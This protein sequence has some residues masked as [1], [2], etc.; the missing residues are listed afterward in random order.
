MK[1]VLYL[2]IVVCLFGICLCAISC[3]EPSGSPEGSGTDSET[4]AG[5][6][7]DPETG[8]T[9]PTEKAGDPMK[10]AFFITLA[11]AVVIWIAALILW[12]DKK[13]KGEAK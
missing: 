13:K 9:A 4:E 12:A 5:A 8:A 3:E 1:K 6:A 11:A 7:T 10:T 2:L